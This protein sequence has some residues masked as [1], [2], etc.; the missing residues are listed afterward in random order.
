MVRLEIIIYSEGC[1]GEELFTFQYGQIRNSI[2]IC[3]SI[4]SCS[5]YIP[6]WLDQK[7]RIYGEE[8]G[9]E[10]IYIPVWLDQKLFL[11]YSLCFLLLYLHSSMVR[12]EM[13][14]YF[15]LCN[16]SSAFTFQYGQI[17]NICIYFCIH[18][19]FSIYIPVWLDQKCIR[20]AKIEPSK[21][22]LHS[23]MV[24]LEIYRAKEFCILMI[25]F[26]FQ[27][28]Q[29]R[30]YSQDRIAGLL[31]RI[32]IPV[33]LDQKY[34]RFTNAKTFTSYLHSSMVRLEMPSKNIFT[35]QDEPFTFQYGQ[36]R[37]YYSFFCKTW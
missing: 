22:N 28:G 11:E 10:K 37:N 15:G 29:I 2:I 3:S 23:S 36:I 26:T 13:P 9:M 20:N 8:T 27:Y 19:K 33:W 30:N 32:Y 12:L 4:V 7:C 21:S 25:V 6:V 17:R 16:V 18:I 14:R 35:V 34:I 1:N 24:R 5:I 31:K